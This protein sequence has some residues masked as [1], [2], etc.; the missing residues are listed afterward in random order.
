MVGLL[1]NTEFLSTA[2][3][4]TVENHLSNPRKSPVLG[5]KTGAAGR[6]WRVLNNELRP[7]IVD[8]FVQFAAP[9]FNKLVHYAGASYG[10][11]SRQSSALRFG[12]STNRNPHVQPCIRRI[13]VLEGID[14]R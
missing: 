4:D 2:I 9:L 6:V 1:Y 5:A 8:Q 10:M 13:P 12:V 3:I 7:L 11:V 14:G